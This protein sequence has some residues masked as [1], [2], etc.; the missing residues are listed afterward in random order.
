MTAWG[1]PH[2]Q[3]KQSQWPND[4][5]VG[6]GISDT[7]LRRARSVVGRRVAVPDEHLGQGRQR[8]GELPVQLLCGRQLSLM[9]SKL[10]LP[11]ARCSEPRPIAINR[12]TPSRSIR[13]HWHEKAHIVIEQ[14]RVHYNT[15]P[16]ERGSVEAV[17]SARFLAPE[18]WTVLSFIH[19]SI[20]SLSK[21]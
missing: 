7:C 6:L 5:L 19:F 14:W 2:E 8:I 3:L 10:A 9:T 1:I 12:E 21:R 4:E 20:A 11:E 18:R 15:K 17:H 13:V 16:R